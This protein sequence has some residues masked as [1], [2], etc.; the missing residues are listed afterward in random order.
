[1]SFLGGVK[2]GFRI[3]HSKKKIFSEVQTMENLETTSDNTNNGVPTLLS[4]EIYKL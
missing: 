4:G 3:V 2:V 1:M